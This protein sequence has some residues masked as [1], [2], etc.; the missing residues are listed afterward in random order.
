MQVFLCAA[1]Y[2][3]ISV[4][5]STHIYQDFWAKLDMA[6]TAVLEYATDEVIEKNPRSECEFNEQ[7]AFIEH[8]L[9]AVQK[10]DYV[11]P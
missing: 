8:E 2:I 3:T 6:S 7:R 9:Q 10:L 5:R 1:D 11:I 4:I